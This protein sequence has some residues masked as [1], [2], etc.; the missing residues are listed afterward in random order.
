[1]KSDGK[2]L[3]NIKWK[4]TI[5]RVVRQAAS[6]EG[7]G[8]LQKDGKRRNENFRRNKS[9]MDFFLTLTSVGVLLLY[10]VPGFILS[11]T[12]AVTTDSL[13]AFSKVL[14]YVCQP[15]LTLYTFDDIDF[16]SVL[17]RDMVMFFFAITVLQLFSIG[18][19]YLI[20]RKRQTEV[21][22]RV[23]TIASTFGNCAFFGVPILESL[24]PG[25]NAVAFS[26]MYF[27]SMS[28]LGWTV[29]SAV[30]AHDKKYISVKK[31]VLNPAVLV[32]AVALPLFIFGVKL[33]EQLYTPVSIVGKMST[34]LCMLVL[35][36]R[37]GSMRIRSVFSGG[38]NYLIV[39][40]KQ[41]IFPLLA[42]GVAWLLPWDEYARQAMFVLACCPVASVV[43]NFSELL[44]EGQEDAAEMLLLGTILSVL[45]MPVML[46]LL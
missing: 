28:L 24:F 42:L 23:Y 32:M 10:A 34:P 33:P 36:I 16:T 3:T 27:A 13:P 8:A 29:A 17:F 41:M 21:R 7:A 2:S 45:T 30:I 37:L 11:R 1:M 40:V 4:I 18:I 9:L 12:K 22:Y 31:I 5:K 6:G 43:L 46:L 38:F 44:G 26:N 39:M 14:M 15:C 25:S 19:F 20:F 35:G